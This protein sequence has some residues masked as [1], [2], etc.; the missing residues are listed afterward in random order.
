M[1]AARDTGETLFNADTSTST[2]D[3]SLR[4]SLNVLLPDVRIPLVTGLP[5][6]PSKNTVDIPEV[7]EVTVDTPPPLKS[8]KVIPV[9]TYPPAVA[10][11]I[12][13][14]VASTRLN[15]GVASESP[16]TKLT[17]PRLVIGR[18]PLPITPVIWDAC[19]PV[20][21]ATVAISPL[22]ETLS[23]PPVKFTVFPLPTVTPSFSKSISFAFLF[24]SSL[25]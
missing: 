22:I 3:A 9:P 5:A 15:A 11:P 16:V 4:V 12:G 21:I 17:P 2:V 1:D 18:F 6:P 25:I 13:Y 24:A 20:E 23:T 10:M 19:T 14:P 8:N 7:T